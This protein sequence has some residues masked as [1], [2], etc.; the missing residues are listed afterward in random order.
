MNRVLWLPAAADGFEESHQL[1]G[2]LDVVLSDGFVPGQDG[3]I[4]CEG[5][6]NQQSIKR[7]PMVPWQSQVPLTMPF[8][9]RQVENSIH[10]F[11]SFQETLPT[12]FKL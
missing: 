8:I 2:R 11:F 6:A 9:D 1:P 3:Q 7:I 5:L 12:F 10:F 4:F